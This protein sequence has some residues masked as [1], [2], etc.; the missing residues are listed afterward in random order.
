MFLP[1]EASGEVRDW[2]GDFLM[3]GRMEEKCGVSTHGSAVG[4]LRLGVWREKVFFLPTNLIWKVLKLGIRAEIT[5]KSYKLWVWEARTCLSTP[6]FLFNI[7]NDWAEN[8]K[9]VCIRLAKI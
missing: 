5:I 9:R 8:K 7:K 6:T 2:P 4:S 3:V 1:A